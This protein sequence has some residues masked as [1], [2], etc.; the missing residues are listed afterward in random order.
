MQQLS[1][2][3][4]KHTQRVGPLEWFRMKRHG[5]VRVRIGSLV[6]RV[7][8][9]R[10]CWVRPGSL[11]G[12]TCSSRRREEHVE[13]AAVIVRRCWLGNTE[14]RGLHPNHGPSP[15]KNSI[16]G[17][18][19]DTGGLTIGASAVVGGSISSLVSD[20]PCGESYDLL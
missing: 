2:V 10:T 13:V 1:R 9:A 20:C 11:M 3:V 18:E 12:S 4:A 6:V 16:V 7:V 17:W 14:K 8:R 15:P 19:P 5:L